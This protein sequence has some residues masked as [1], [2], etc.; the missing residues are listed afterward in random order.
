MY[1]KAAMFPLLLPSKSA[2]SSR[3]FTQR[4]FYEPLIE[5]TFTSVIWE[6]EKIGRTSR[7]IYIRK[8]DQSDT[9]YTVCP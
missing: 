6:G 2:S 7:T 9:A 8:H 3:F 5:S 4:G 1:G